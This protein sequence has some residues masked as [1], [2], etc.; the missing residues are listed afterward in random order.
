MN[1]G[2]L[3]EILSHFELNFSL[4]LSDVLVSLK[5]THK[6]VYSFQHYLLVIFHPFYGSSSFVLHWLSVCEFIFPLPDPVHWFLYVFI[7]VAYA[8][9]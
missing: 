8:F 1:S 6:T 4:V 5:K 7:P 9:D 2:L 3:S